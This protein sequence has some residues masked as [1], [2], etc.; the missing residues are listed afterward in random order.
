MF[1]HMKEE[2]HGLPDD[3]PVMT[4][5]SVFDEDDNEGECHE[6]WFFFNEEGLVDSGVYVLEHQ[7]CYWAALSECDL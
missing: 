5:M 1:D 2:T 7:S 3:I 4:Y 6:Y